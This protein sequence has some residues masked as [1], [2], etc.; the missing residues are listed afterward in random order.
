MRILL[1]PTATEGGAGQSDPAPPTPPAQSAPLDAQALVAELSR[2]QAENARFSAAEAARQAA[3]A[4]ART[5]QQIAKGEADALVAAHNAALAERDRKLAQIVERTKKGELDRALTAAL[6]GRNLA[7]PSTAK[8][9]VTLF[10]DDFEVVDGP[11]G[12]YIVRS[13]GDYRPPDAVIAERL[14]SEEYAHFVSAAHRG[15]GN[16]GGT[17][18]APTGQPNAQAVS[19]DPEQAI[20]DR[21]R[22][23][24]AP[25]ANVPSWQRPF[26]S[27]LTRN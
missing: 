15:G 10:R 12:D 9:L 13:K 16:A 24:N 19:N 7:H 22:Q 2:L 1:N 20:F 23:A 5:R 17:T 21:W 27:T 6:A 4:E 14:A 8:Q 3:E 18:P 25:N 11:N 26:L